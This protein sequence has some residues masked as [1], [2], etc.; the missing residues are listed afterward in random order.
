VEVV[1]DV[2]V[3]VSAVLSGSGPSAQLV[4]AMRDDRLSVVACP[5]LVAELTGVLR[6]DRFRR[7]LS[8]EEVDEY[9]GEI[10]GLCRMVDDPDPVPAVLRDPDDDYL[11]AL[12]SESGA[13]AIVSG[14]L[15]LHEATGLPVDVLT[16]PEA[17]TRLAE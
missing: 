4:T 9:S 12:A 2:N 3:F 10:E 14:D 1:L 6:R 5:A 13:D 11:V 17:L 7:Y 8:L 16:P 15:D